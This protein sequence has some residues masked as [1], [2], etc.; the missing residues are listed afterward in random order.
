[1]YYVYVLQSEKNNRYYTG[2][3]SDLQRRMSEHNAGK[4]PYDKLNKP[5]ALVYHEVVPTRSEAVRRERFYKSG[6]GRERIKQI[7][8][9]GL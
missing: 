3:T 8:G 1:M 7:I 2:S 6:Q 9:T 4:S 5:F